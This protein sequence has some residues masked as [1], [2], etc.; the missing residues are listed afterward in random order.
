MKFFS[1]IRK[2]FQCN[3]LSISERL[4]T[5]EATFAITCQELPDMKCIQSICALVPERDTLTLTFQ[6]DS[7]DIVI[8]SNK[9]S[10]TPDFSDLID[11]LT[12]DDNIDISV[13]IDKA[14]A[15]DRFS[16]FDFT[17]FIEDLLQRQLLD[18]M[19]WFSEHLQEQECLMFEVFDY[20]IS[21][22][23]RTM[24]FESSDDAV[25]KPKVVRSQRLGAC[26]ETSYF[27]NM[28]VFE[29]IPDDFIIEG[30]VRA[31]NSL[32]PLFGKIATILSLVYVASS[33]AISEDAVNVQIS[34]QRRTSHELNLNSIHE[35]EK[36]ISIYSWIFT[37]GNP[38]DKALIAHNVISLHCKYEVLLN[39]DAAI[40]DAIKTNYNLYLRNNVSQY[41]DMKR[42]IAKFIQNIVAQV[43]D[44]AV[45][46]LGKFKANLVAIFGFLFTVVL[47][48]VGGSQKWDDIFTRHTIY[49]IEVF[50]AGSLVYLLICFYETRYKLKKT[51]QG[52][53]E[54]KENYKDVLS[55]AEIKDAFKEDILL[56]D[57]EKSVRKGMIGWS[58]IWGGLLV[59]VIIIIEV[60]T[61]NHGLIVWLWYKLF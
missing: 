23:T 44:Y 10:K 13:R 54:L 41:L 38:T 49:L 40:F 42:D 26:K 60:F 4:N 35:D 22:S 18:V 19:K 31:G 47:T 11:G 9:Q 51:K 25:F 24:A 20:D 39:L 17:S 6:N 29:I 50:V 55:D 48:K 33:A 56:K 7:N 1:E 16:I 14:V 59:L 27:Y 15:R 34:G 37:D 61:I 36:W 12:K 57:T 45:A 46:I 2:I 32:K 21:F 3:N 8:L 5:V 30:I 58:S 28:N 52:Y 53:Y 43:G